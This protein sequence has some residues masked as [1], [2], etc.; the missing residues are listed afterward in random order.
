MANTKQVVQPKQEN[1]I[2]TTL[3]NIGRV[4]IAATGLCATTA[5]RTESLTNRAFDSAELMLESFA[6]DLAI[7]SK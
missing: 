5:E 7:P 1:A 4:C 3:R 6:D 2:K